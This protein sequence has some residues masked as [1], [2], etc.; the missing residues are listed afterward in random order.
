MHRCSLFSH[1]CGGN[2]SSEK[3]SR[4]A[5]GTDGSRRHLKHAAGWQTFVFHAIQWKI[6]V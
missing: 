2:R 3:L 5:A 1:F 4:A 6:M